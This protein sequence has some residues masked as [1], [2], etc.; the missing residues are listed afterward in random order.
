MDEYLFGP[1]LLICPVTEP[2]KDGQST[3]RVYLPKGTDWYDFYTEERFEGGQEITAYVGI[4][5]IPVYV[6]AG[7][8]VPVMEP[9][10]STA[11]MEGQDIL[12]QVYGGADGAFTLYEDAGDGYGYEKGEYCLTKI[13]YRDRKKT[14]E[15]KSEGDMAFRRGRIRSRLIGVL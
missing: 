10:E 1:A 14:V 11:D 6:R 9:G 7:S 2:M 4:D 13:R 15:W 12:L 5:H 3:R 8:I